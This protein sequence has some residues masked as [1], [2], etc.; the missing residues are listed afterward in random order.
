MKML[1]NQSGFTLVE[2]M[3]V[4]AIIGILSA[5]AIPNF[6][7]YQAKSKT[8]E[9]KLHLANI[10]T[11][12][13]ASMSDYDTYATCLS[14]MGVTAPPNGSNFYAFGFNNTFAG[15]V[16]TITAAGGTCVASAINISY[17]PQTKVPGGG[18]AVAVPTAGAT[19]A[20]TF[21]AQARGQITSGAQATVGVNSWTIN[22]SKAIATDNAGM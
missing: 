20:T 14:N 19:T 22:E 9:A 10:Y 11:A 17:W 15:G 21:T 3:V 2:L 6:K 12:E 1:K 7:K 13:S 5:V 16:A 18:T 4:V 8:S